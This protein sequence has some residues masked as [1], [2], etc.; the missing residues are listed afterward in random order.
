MN[1]NAEKI[2]PQIDEAIFLIENEINQ[3]V[4]KSIDARPLQ[5]IRSRL[6]GIKSCI[7]Q[8]DGKKDPGFTPDIARMAIEIFSINDLLVDQL[9]RIECE[10]ERLKPI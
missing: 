9:C 2:I 7:I 6:F 5:F 3:A 1:K 4:E 10:Y 8:N